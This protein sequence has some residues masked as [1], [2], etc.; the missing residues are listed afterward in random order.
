ML[1]ERQRQE[2]EALAQ[3]RTSFKA[4]E[5]LKNSLSRDLKDKV[6]HILKSVLLQ[7]EMSSVTYS[8]ESFGTYE[9]VM[10]RI[11]ARELKDKGVTCE[12]QWHVHDSD[13]WMT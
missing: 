8:N 2:A 11:P 12:W 10:S 4:Q 9:G 13:M 5:D 1:E 7:I 6:S 3:L